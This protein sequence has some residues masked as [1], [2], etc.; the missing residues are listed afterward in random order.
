[1]DVPSNLSETVLIYRYTTTATIT[2]VVYEYIINLGS[3]V[4]YLWRRRITLGTVLMAFCRYFPFI[5]IFQFIVYTRLTDANPEACVTGYRL[6]GS[7][8]YVEFIVALLVLY[9][10]AYAVWGGSK[11]ILSLLAGVLG[12]SSYTMFLFV[13]NA[14]APAPGISTPCVYILGDNNLWIAVALLLSGEAT[15]LG[16]LLIKSIQHARALRNFATPSRSRNLLAVMAQDGIGYFACTLVLSS[17]NLVVLRRVRGPPDLRDFL[18]VIQGALQSILCS[19]LL[20]HVHA[21]NENP[22]GTMATV[23]TIVYYD[24][25]LQSKLGLEIELRPRRGRLSLDSLTARAKPPMSS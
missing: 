2:L 8:I 3:E 19:R 24:V 10:R 16:L 1:M 18:F 12:G 21:V 17:A 11:I 20:F 7:F 14:K 13:T 23:S 15:A 4:R 5:N 6:S 22:G 25:F 9:V